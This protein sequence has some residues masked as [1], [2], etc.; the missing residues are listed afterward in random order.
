MYGRHFHIFKHKLLPTIVKTQGINTVIAVLFFYFLPYF[1]IAPKTILFLDLLVSFVLILAW[2]FY[3]ANVLVRVSGERALMLGDGVSVRE[4]KKYLN[5]N[6]GGQ[7][8]LVSDEVFGYDEADRIAEVVKDKEVE[9]LVL[10][11]HRDGASN[12]FAKLYNQV[13]FINLQSLYEDFFSHVPID[14]VNDN[15]FLANISLKPK[16]F[17][18][19]AK[20]VMDIS[21][22]SLLLIP[23]LII[24]PFVILAI[25]LETKG[26]A[27]IK[28]IRVGALGQEVPIYKFRT[29]TGDDSGDQVLNTKLEVTKVGSVLRKTRIDELPQLLNVI[30]GSLSL[31]GP[32]PEFPA[33]VRE[34]E[35]DIPYYGI[36]HTIKPGLSGWAQIYHDNHPHGKT[37]QEA[38]RE[39]LSY[40]LFYIK[41]RSFILDLKIA[42]KTV[43]ILLSRKGI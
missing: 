2:R 14:L 39:K 1:S 29:M 10:D 32:R 23:S 30:N 4:F 24:F 9:V 6:T 26:P 40:D 41:N 19:F 33:L 12:I 37:D 8:Q 42:L 13:H 18:S 36:R 20:R 34:Y 15:W 7:V 21:I 35:K 5:N 16:R 17:Y 31:I 43:R 22:S 38:T 11:F 25:K 3:V 27:F 28:Q